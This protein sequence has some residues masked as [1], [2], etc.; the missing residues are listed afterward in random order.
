MSNNEDSI[1]YWPFKFLMNNGRKNLSAKYTNL[2]Y[3]L[4][5]I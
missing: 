1:M 4:Y 2:L 5:V 3:V